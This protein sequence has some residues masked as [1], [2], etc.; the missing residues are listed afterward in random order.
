MKIDTIIA[1][2]AA[3][4][5]AISVIVAIITFVITN[6]ENNKREFIKTFDQIYKKTF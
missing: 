4:I 1:I 3:I 6:L 5:S 2:T